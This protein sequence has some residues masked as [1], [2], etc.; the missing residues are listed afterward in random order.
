MN[1]F[2]EGNEHPEYAVKRFE[3][4]LRLN[5]EYFFDRDDLE[6]IVEFYKIGRAHV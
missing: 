4:M 6:S 3:R 2:S 1:E 5:E